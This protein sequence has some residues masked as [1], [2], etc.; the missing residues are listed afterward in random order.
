MSIMFP[1][2][3]CKCILKNSMKVKSVNINYFSSLLGTDQ[4]IS[5]FCNYI[6]L[7]FS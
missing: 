5:R 4:A 7:S 3:F 2:F 1:Y 6:E